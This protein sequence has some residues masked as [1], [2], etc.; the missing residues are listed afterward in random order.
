MRRILKLPAF[1]PIEYKKHQDSLIDNSSF[2][3]PNVVWRAHNRADG[4]P[5][6]GHGGHHSYNNQGGYNR[7][8]GGNYQQ[9]S[10]PRSS[11]DRPSTGANGGAPAG[12]QPRSYT[13]QQQ[14][15]ATGNTNSSPRGNASQPSFTS[16]SPRNTEGAAVPKPPSRWDS[17]NSNSSTSPRSAG[18]AAASEN[19]TAAAASNAGSATSPRAGGAP[20]AGAWRSG[21]AAANSNAWNKSAT[22][23]TATS[24]NSA[25]STAAAPAPAATAAVAGTDGTQSNSLGKNLGG[26]FKSQLSKGQEDTDTSQAST[27][28]ASEGKHQVTYLDV[29]H[30]LFIIY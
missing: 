7:D 11:G 5:G 19:T 28:N 9:G 13:Q 12:F 2:R 26:W 23:T 22:S 20:A 17:L 6:H 18:A 8:G 4:P 16:G 10:S 27:S 30:S 29:T 25:Q 21:S 1:V 24:D 14:P 15:G 3:N